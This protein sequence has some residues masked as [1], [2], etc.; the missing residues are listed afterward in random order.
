MSGL[1]Q[2]A[3]VVMEQRARRPHLAIV[4]RRHEDV[5][6]FMWLT[7][8]DSAG[9]GMGQT[10]AKSLAELVPA[11]D[12]VKVYY[13]WLPSLAE[14]FAMRSLMSLLEAAPK[15]ISAMTITHSIQRAMVAASTEG[16]IFKELD[17][18][19]GI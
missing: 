10:L 5:V 13:K 14:G 15:D 9:D 12:G 8:M 19:A 1:E 11:I 18:G 3:G 17:P 7:S 6:G 2:L 4:A 16:D